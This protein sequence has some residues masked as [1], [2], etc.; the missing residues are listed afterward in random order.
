MRV[1]YQI[2]AV[3]LEGYDPQATN[4]AWIAV[5]SELVDGKRKSLGRTIYVRRSFLKEA[6]FGAVVLAVAHEMAHVVF[7]KIERRLKLYHPLDSERTVDVIAMYMGCAEYYAAGHEYIV[8]GKQVRIGYLQFQEIRIALI[9]IKAMRFKEGSEDEE[10]KEP[11]G[12]TQ[13]LNPAVKGVRGGGD[14]LIENHGIPTALDKRKGRAYR[15]L[16]LGVVLALV[17]GVIG[18]QAWQGHMEQMAAEEMRQVLAR[19]RVEEALA[20]A[21]AA[22][23]RAQEEALKEAADKKVIEA[24]KKKHS[25]R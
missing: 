18:L 12:E 1:P 17:L 8:D 23:G 22:R 20:A 19:K 25:Q 4:P 2:R 6:T 5:K 11:G 13:W 16:L 10:S 15:M 14:T 9:A 24:Q 3:I 21:A 7:S